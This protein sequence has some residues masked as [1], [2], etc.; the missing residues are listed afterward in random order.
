MTTSLDNLISCMN[1]LHESSTNAIKVWYPNVIEAIGIAL[2]I[3]IADITVHSIN[4]TADHILMIG[5]YFP[6]DVYQDVGIPIDWLDMSATELSDKIIDIIK[7]EDNSVLGFSSANL[8]LDQ[9]RDILY[10]SSTTLETTQ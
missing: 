9:V 7:E 5:C 1:E 10:F 3:N 2:E 6:E 8:T 4:V